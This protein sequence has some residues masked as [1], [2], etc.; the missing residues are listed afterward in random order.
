[1]GGISEINKK[2]SPTPLLSL[3]FQEV[4]REWRFIDMKQQF[5]IEALDLCTALSARAKP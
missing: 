3:A 4:T 2:Y 5:E 1:M